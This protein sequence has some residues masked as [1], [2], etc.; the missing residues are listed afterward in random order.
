MEDRRI[1]FV[2]EYEAQPAPRKVWLTRSIVTS[3]IAGLGAAAWVFGYFR[4]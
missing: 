4:F 3:L 2:D 1:N